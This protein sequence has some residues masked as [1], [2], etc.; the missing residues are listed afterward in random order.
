MEADMLGEALIE[1]DLD[2]EILGDAL[3][4]ELIEADNE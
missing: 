4:L 3:M 1:D 2:D